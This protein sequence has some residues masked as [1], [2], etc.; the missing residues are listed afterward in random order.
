[1]TLDPG[2]SAGALDGEFGS[3]TEAA[4]LA[5]QHSEGLLLDG[6]AGPRTLLVPVAVQLLGRRLAWSRKSAHGPAVAVCV[7]SRHRAA[8]AASASFENARAS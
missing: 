6:I 4:V 8:A 2:S 3:A 7:S 1:M 5:F